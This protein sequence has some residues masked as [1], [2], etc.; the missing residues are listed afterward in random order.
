LRVLF[1]GEEVAEVFFQFINRHIDTEQG[2]ECNLEFHTDLVCKTATQIS[3]SR[4]PIWRGLQTLAFYLDSNIFKYEGFDAKGK[5][6]VTVIIPFVQVNSIQ[7]C[8][9][10]IR[11]S[12]TNKEQQMQTL[13]P[14]TI[15]DLR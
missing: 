3:R 5:K 10:K 12:N 7:A 1:N 2:S 14:T 4:T 13:N 9:R 11:K 8:S 15:Q 6:L